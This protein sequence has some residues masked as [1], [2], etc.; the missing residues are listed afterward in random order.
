MVMMIYLENK[1]NKL[2]VLL[3]PVAHIAQLPLADE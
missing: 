2:L 3:T 1:E